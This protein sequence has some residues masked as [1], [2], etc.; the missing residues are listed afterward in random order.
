MTNSS[1]IS[2]RLLAFFF[3]MLGASFAAAQEIQ[4][5]PTKGGVVVTLPADK[6]YTLLPG[7]EKT[8]TLSMLCLR[9]GN[10]ASHILMFSPGG[11]VA[12]DNPETSPKNGVVGLSMTIGGK[13]Q[14]TTWIPYN[15]PDTYAYFGK[16]EPERV[17]FFESLFKYDTASIDFKPYLT[18]VENTSV[19]AV[20]KMHEEM[21]KHSE[22]TMR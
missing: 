17:E 14:I 18:G 7:E 1:S 3:I 13:K 9:K 11:A 16:T 21:A 19:F 5:S 10:K 12:E 20:G 4:V 8:A 15:D 6:P 22:C 2:I